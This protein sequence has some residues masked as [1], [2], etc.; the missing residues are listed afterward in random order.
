MLINFIK[1]GTYGY[2]RE[3]R[4][5]IYNFISNNN[6]SL[7]RQ[8][9]VEAG[10][11][12]DSL[13]I[14]EDYDVCQRLGRAGWLLYFCPEVSSD[15]RA[16]KNLRGLLKQWWN[17]GLHLAQGYRRHYPGRALV[18]LGSPKWQDYDNPEPIRRGLPVRYGRLRQSVSV[19][20]HMSLFVMMHAA[21]AA[22]LFA[23][24]YGNRSLAWTM[25]M[26]STAL[27]LGYAR[28]DFRNLR[29]DGWRKA[30]GL[31]TIRF[32]VNSAF[33][34]GGLL[35]GGRRGAFYI[36]PTIHTRVGAGEPG[37]PRPTTTGAQGKRCKAVEP[38]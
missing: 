16:R 13:R 10:G 28:A 33:V 38:S 2:L 31:F 19:F 9:I 24:V 34:W 11:Y 6:L 17:Y 18:S 15:H 7:R 3:D 32:A 4:V 22:L 21:G 8:A 12:D 30:L 1:K 25:A 36:F 20:V 29:R 27:L 5:G 35:G 26:I 14:A 37:W 23:I